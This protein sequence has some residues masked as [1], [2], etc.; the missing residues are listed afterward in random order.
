[1]NGT[2][3]ERYLAIYAGVLTVVFAGAVLGGL[4][5]K[6]NPAR[7]EELDVQRLNLVEPDGALR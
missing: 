7:F 4:T 6:A 5:G 1:M 3:S 2:R